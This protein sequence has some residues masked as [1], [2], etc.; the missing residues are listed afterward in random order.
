MCDKGS[1]NLTSPE[2]WK[3]LVKKKARHG[4]VDKGADCWDRAAATY[5]D[6][7]ACS[8]YLSQLNTI[9]STLLK[10]GALH[11]DARVL[12]VAC[13]TG[14]YGIRMAPHCLEYTGLDISRSMLDQFEAK[15]QRYNLRNIHIIHADW[16]QQKLQDRFDLVFCSLSPI[17]RYME[18]IDTLLDASKRFVAIV[19]WAGVKDNSLS[20]RISQRIFGQPDRRSCM[21]VLTLFN[22]LYTLGY[23]PDLRFFHG[24]WQRTRKIAE[25][26]ESISWQM[27]MKRPLTPEEKSIISEEVES[28]GKDGYVSVATRVRLA[29][30]LLDKTQ[31]ITIQEECKI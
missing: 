12:D 9:I 23:A 5:D 21:D 18:N 15:I 7:E 14:N 3:G 13:G 2:F 25:Q 11:A 27:E 28:E 22:Y 29:F 19:S 8:D 16:L 10:A 4:N 31:R 6:L 24:N 30:L 26:I 20:A 1:I 17:L